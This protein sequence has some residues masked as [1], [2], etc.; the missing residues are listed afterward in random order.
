MPLTN[1]HNHVTQPL[2]QP[3]EGSQLPRLMLFIVMEGCRQHIDPL[4]TG[5]HT[6]M[7]KYVARYPDQKGIALSCLR[8]FCRIQL[9][10][11]HRYAA[12]HPITCSVPAQIL[13]G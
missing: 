11:V 10:F 13:A 3:P 12:Q 1:V 9:L 7:Y 5:T 6:H 4:I 8:W 2:L